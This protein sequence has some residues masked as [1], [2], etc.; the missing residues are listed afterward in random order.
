MNRAKSV[1]RRTW[2]SS[3]YIIWVIGFTVIPLG[4]IFKYALTS[5]EGGVSLE[6][7]VAIFDSIHLKAMVFSLEI[8]IGC[9]LICILLSYPLV[10]ALR[11]LGMGRQGFTMFILIL[12]M[13]MNFILRI[14]A[15]QMILSNNGILNFLLTRLGMDALPLANTGTAIMIGVVYDYLPYMVL[16]IF[17]AVAEID[18]D[19]IEAARDLGANGFTVF[20]KIIFPLSIPGLLS[21]IVMVFVPSMTSFVISDILGGGKLQLIGNIIEQE[22]T[23]SSNWNLGSGL[24][25]SLM[26]FVLISMAF[27][28]KNDVEGKGSAIW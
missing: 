5:R 4:V 16:P 3:P 26:I 17:N 10:L 23:K 13:W 7:I 6:N 2:L 24:S 8:A 15:W 21:G 27:T 14:L 11:Y 18:E 25:V 12:P 28:T 20:R 19:I 9:T 1:N 22:F